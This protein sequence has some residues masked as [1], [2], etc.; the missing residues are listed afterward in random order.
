M[1]NLNRDSAIG[2]SQDFS[3]IS[4]L[5]VEDD[6]GAR[7]LLCSIIRS[8]FPE[9]SLHE[10]PD[11]NAALGLYGQHPCDIIITDINMPKVNGLDMVRHIKTIN[12]DVL[13]IA[14]TAYSDT[15]YLLDSIEIGVNHYIIK[16]LDHKKL[17]QAIRKCIETVTQWRTAAAELEAR[18]RE[19]EAFNYSVSHDLRSPLTAISGFSQVIMQRGTELDEQ[20]KAYLHGIHDSTLEMK[21][22]I[23]TLLN[24][25]RLSQAE[26][27]LASVD[28]SAMAEE[29]C[30]HLHV[31]APERP[32]KI[33]IAKKVTA[34]GDRDLLKI[35]LENLLGNAWKFTGQ[36]RQTLIEFGMIEGRE[37]PTYFVR[38]NG[39]GFDNENADRIF[40]PFKRLV[41]NHEFEGSGIGLA[42]VQR[43]IQRHGGEVWASGE[44]GKGATI[45]FSIPTDRRKTAATTTRKMRKAKSPP[46]FT[47]ML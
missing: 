39:I 14:L 1:N 37:P 36:N 25:S 4:V 15:S 11:G 3:P 5:C 32:V 26:L 38:D 23:D 8:I 20:C 24:F 45:F 12:P 6:A 13:V 43:I 10:A 22:L 41:E 9:L 30:K 46:T 17:V 40:S 29:I 42:T 16:P 31:T 19:L 2:N 7:K 18:Y 27:Q 44:L 21:R 33:L 47:T 28:L 35:V 34:Q